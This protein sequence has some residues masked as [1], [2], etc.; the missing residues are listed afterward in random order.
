[1]LRN[2]KGQM[3]IVEAMLT[4][5][6]VITG[7]SISLYL[8]N[9]YSVIER[10]TIE[11]TGINVMN[12]LVNPEIVEKIVLN[13]SSWQIEIKG[14]L[15]NLLPPGVYYQ[16]TV[17]S[18]LTGQVFGEVT[19]IVDQLQFSSADTTTLRQVVTLSMPLRKSEFIPLDVMLII[20]VSGSMG[21][22]LPGDERTKLKAAQDAAKIFLDQLNS[23]KD[24]VGLVTFNDAAR[25][26][27]D[28]TYDF[29]SI[30]N[31]IESLRSGGYTNIGDG[32][33]NA[34]APLE[35]GGR[36][37]STIWVMILLSDGMANRPL[38]Q[39]RQNLTYAREYALE[40][41]E[42]ACSVGSSQKLRI[43]TIGLG[44]KDDIDESLLQAIAQMSNDGKYYYTPSA[45]D[46]EEI[47]TTIARD[48][49]F[50]VQYD[51]VIL[52]LTLIKPG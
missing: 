38:Y 1:M 26:V 50:T 15:E 45:E 33:A 36:R 35:S 8:A 9:V 43:Y 7:F 49:V 27:A 20:D 16:L 46:L 42:Y 39:G 28:L 29:S 40:K 11:K 19:N 6:I 5:L 31:K 14:V 2:N 23:S 4:C 25:L 3:R 24:R 44:A 48:L 30:K 17:S 34:T 47:Y 41:A 32:I 22:R 52:E 51:I 37:G 10:G 21:S 13:E 12:I 18:T